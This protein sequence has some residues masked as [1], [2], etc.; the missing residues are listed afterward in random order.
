MVSG[1][2]RACSIRRGSKFCTI[3]RYWR[4][5]ISILKP[6]SASNHVNHISEKCVKFMRS[7]LIWAQAW[8]GLGR[9]PAWARLGWAR[10][11]PRR[12]RSCVRCTNF[13]FNYV[14][15]KQE[16][17]LQNGLRSR[18]LCR[19]MSRKFSYRIMDILGSQGFSIKYLMKSIGGEGF[20]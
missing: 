7:G 15:K 4:I 1:A 3:W 2:S 5:Q 14:G 10:A 17:F 13:V 11:G 20:P 16:L 12:A 8:A 9:V 19:K 18:P 6:D